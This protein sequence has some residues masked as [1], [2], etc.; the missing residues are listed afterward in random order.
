MRLRRL[1]CPK[2]C[3]GL[4]ETQEYQWCSSSL[5]ASRP[6]TQ[7]N[8]VFQSKGRMRLTPQVNSQAGEIHC[9]LAFLSYS[10]SADRL[11]PT[12]MRVRSPS[13]L[14]SLL[15]QMTISPRIMFDYISG[16]PVA[17]SS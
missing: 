10:V 15:T 4:L 7:E 3:R 12:H 2:T 14:L 17:Q 11:R 6:G 5:Q 13:T 8:A 1:R 9:Y 16:H